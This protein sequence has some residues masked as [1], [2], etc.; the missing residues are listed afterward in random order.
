MIGTNKG[1]LR[2]K[3]LMIRLEALRFLGHVNPG[4]FAFRCSLADDGLLC[5]LALL[6]LFLFNSFL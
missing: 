2:E 6:D 3:V 5:L 4:S 1:V